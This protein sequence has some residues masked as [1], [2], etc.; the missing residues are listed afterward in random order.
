MHCT[1]AQQISTTSIFCL[2]NNILYEQLIHFSERPKDYFRACLTVLKVEIRM[3]RDELFSS[4][5]AFE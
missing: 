2:N 1:D 4:R 3:G 5:K